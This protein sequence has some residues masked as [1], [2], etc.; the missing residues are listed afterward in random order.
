MSTS[1][2]NLIISQEKIEPK[3]KSDKI[4]PLLYYFQNN[5]TSQDPL[6]PLSNLLNKN[7]KTGWI[8]NRFCTYPQEIIIEF[9]SFVNIKQI[10]ILIN[11][12]KIPTIIEFINCTYL[13]PENNKIRNTNTNE[14]E[15]SSKRRK[16]KI[17]E[18]QYKNIGFIK[19]SSNVETNYKARELRK[20][21][22]NV[23]TKKIKL[24]IHRNYSNSL[25]TFCQVGIVNLNFYGFIL[26]NEENNDYQYNNKKKLTYADLCL[27]EE[28]E[29]F[30]DSFFKQKMDKKSEEKFKE[31]M[32]EM[33]KKKECEE[34]DECKLIKREIDQLKKIT[35]KIYNLEMY[36]NDCVQRNDF[37]NAKKIK[38]D[39]DIFKKM[40]NDYL[41]KSYENENSNQNPNEENQDTQNKNNLTAN[42]INA[43][44]S[45]NEENKLNND[46]NM[47]TT[48]KLKKNLR[49]S[50]TQHDIFNISENQFDNVVL[51]T[52]QKRNNSNL[53]SISN[54][55]NS[56]SFDNNISI[57]N[58]NGQLD[59]LNFQ[60]ENEQ[61]EKQPMEDLLP[62]IKIKYEILIKVLGEE[63]IQKVFSK[64]IYYKEEG[65]EVLNS[66]AK[67]IIIDSQ[68][69]TQ[70]T[71][72]YIVSLI[73]ICFLFMD[74]RHPSIVS[75]SLE[76]FINILKAITERS[77]TNKTEYDFKITKRIL[78]KIKSKLN[79]I[80]KKV[81]LTAS[82]LYCYM[83]ET[84][85]CEYNS[86]IL[87][88]VENDV[89]EYFNKLGILNN[90]NYN[91]Q[92][93]TSKG[94]KGIGITAN[95][96]PDLSKQLI[97]TKM[98][99]FLEIFTKFEKN[100]N[101]KFDVKKFP[102]N[103]VGDFIIIN[104]NHPKEEV[105]DITKEVLIKYIHIFGN[106]ILGKLKM[107]I[108]NKELNKLIQDKK[109]LQQQLLLYKEE[110]KKK[111]LPKYRIEDINVNYYQKYLY[112]DKNKKLSQKL[113]PIP[114][115]SN[116]NININANSNVNNN[117]RNN[118]NLNIKNKNKQNNNNN[119]KL[120]KSSSQPRYHISSKIKLKPITNNKT[121]KN[122]NNK[123]IISRNNNDNIKNITEIKEESKNEE[124]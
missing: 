92:M 78:N 68:K 97:I 5:I 44:T 47:P 13:P 93:S 108:D 85:F 17:V 81:R 79:H 38:K 2:E 77:S 72:K 120:I 89:N 75:H 33:E 19:L 110:E 76:L 11:E 111:N 71:N 80:S 6:Y 39:I 48:N 87:E 51:P 12:S 40:L 61:I 60:N 37:D 106:Q 101:K 34:Y 100:E 36:K 82:K 121:N 105:R 3:K 124:T 113:P 56:N 14:E 53:N 66:K 65:F 84:D 32:E 86:L 117:I 9:H 119:K 96:K 112:R 83:L 109:E 54:I 20:I 27:D 45:M 88:L 7:N 103:I 123:S 62:D 67:E 1:N 35:F 10:N 42:N 70:E 46:K 63:T 4:I 43:N 115:I 74:D 26:N 30:N 69:T 57:S 64:Y 90:N 122:V 49:I 50:R 107:F 24:I 41:N 29:G 104:I 55:N 28:I 18:Y 98:N 31:L 23:L 116:K 15:L 21:F 59:S 16:K 118:N 94:I 95:L 73:N 22:I 91:F 114:E 102:Q 25:N 58:T 52:I 8:S 99:I